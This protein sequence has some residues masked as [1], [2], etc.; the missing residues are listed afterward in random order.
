MKTKKVKRIRAWADVGSHGGVFEFLSGPV[1]IS[2]PS[3]LHIFAEKV[4]PDL[5]EVIISQAKPK[6]TKSPL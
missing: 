2:Y 4:S 3:L 6:K 5:V 1:A